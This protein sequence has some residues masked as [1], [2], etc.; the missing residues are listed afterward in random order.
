[1]AKS[2]SQIDGGPCFNR[3]AVPETRSLARA[4]LITLTLTLLLLP[5][6][7]L[8]WLFPEHRDIAALAIEKLDPAQREALDKLWSEARSGHETRLCPEPADPAQ[9]AKPTCIDYASWPAIAGDHSCSANE[10]VTTVL[11]APWILDV[12]QISA[13][14]KAQLAAAKRRDQQ[15]N[16]VRD[17]NLALQRADPELATRASSNDAHFLLARPDVGI[18]PAAYAKLTLGA[19]AQLN[20][21]GTY[22]WY[23]L[24]A[25]AQAARIAHSDLAPEARAKA[26]L[27]VLGDEAFAAHFLEDAFAAGHVAGSWGDT[28]VRLGT[29]DY[30]NEY[31]LE[32]VTWKGKHFVALGDGYMRPED[33]ERAAAA[34]RD[35]LAQ[36]LEALAGKAPEGI[37]PLGDGDNQP[38]AFNVCREPRFP[39]GVGTSA[40]VEMILVPIITQTPVP[41][42]ATGKGE[43][44]RFRGE[45][46]PFL[47]V[48]S[49][50]SVEGPESGFGSSQNTASAVG[51]LELAVRAGFGLEGVMSESGDGLVFAEL[52]LRYDSHSTSNSCDNC[53]LTATIPARSAV[54]LRLRCPFWLIPGDLILAAPVLAFTSPKTLTKMGVEAANGGLIPYESGIATPVG[55]FQFVLGREIGISFYGNYSFIIPTA[56]V[57]PNNATVLAL[58]SIQYEFPIVEYR[59]FRSFS[60]D[61]SSSVLIQLYYA[62]DRP[63]GTGTVTSPVGAP[64]PSLQ[65]IQMLG[66]RVVFDWRHYFR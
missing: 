28:A 51:S 15:V 17:S 44:P 22:A 61:Q 24:R 41:A 47:G 3:R 26:A 5:R 10:M 57:P 33:Q 46:G 27:A 14:L 34:V 16:A 60:L 4:L 59:P 45:L 55:R 35:S 9:P 31:G 29:H 12:A 7:G 65:N 19:G 37:T 39:T 49:A 25:V 36:V 2:F 20:A 21:L 32:A 62:I 58:S 38:D 23:H 56:G 50:A 11:D 6:V 63:S 8:A 66:L 30:Y 13:K 43:L 40:S 53:N 48:S 64:A 1:M 52:G 42:L 54:T 18:E